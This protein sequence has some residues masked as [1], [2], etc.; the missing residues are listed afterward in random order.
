MGIFAYWMKRASARKQAMIKYGALQ[1]VSRISLLT[2]RVL[3]HELV[4]GPSVKAV[5]LAGAVPYARRVHDVT[6]AMGDALHG[7]ERAY[8]VYL[9]SDSQGK[10][11]R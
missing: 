10:L 3:A 9:P 6:P 7:R 1:E 4:L 5:V 2:Y 11:R 8:I